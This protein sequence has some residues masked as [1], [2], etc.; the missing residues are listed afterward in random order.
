M[1]QERKH[2]MQGKEE[3]ENFRKVG[4]VKKRYHTISKI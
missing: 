4:A 3:K 2:R 1:D